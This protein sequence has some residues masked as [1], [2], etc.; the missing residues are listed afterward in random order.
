MH[1]ARQLL[2]VFR[3]AGKFQDID[4]AYAVPLL[5]SPADAAVAGEGV[6]TEILPDEESL[7]GVFALRHLE[8]DSRTVRVIALETPEL[9]RREH[10]QGG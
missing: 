10:T 8:F 7:A 2:E 6:V 3:F 4:P 1:D 5:Q 9:R